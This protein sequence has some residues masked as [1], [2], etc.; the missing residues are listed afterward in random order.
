LIYHLNLCLLGIRL[1]A[2]PIHIVFK[3]LQETRVE[4]TDNGNGN[5]FKFNKKKSGATWLES[6]ATLDNILT[7][8]KNSTISSSTA[9]TSDS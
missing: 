1:D 7:V 8:S 9:E 6:Y 3:V 4:Q 5:I 2:F